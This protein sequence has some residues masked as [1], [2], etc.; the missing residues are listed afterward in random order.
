MIYIDDLVV[1]ILDPNTAMPIL[2]EAKHPN[3]LEIQEYIGT[4]IEKAFLDMNK[5]ELETI[6]NLGVKSI[7]SDLGKRD[8]FLERSRDFANFMYEILEKNAMEPL[9][10]VITRF[11]REGQEYVAIFYMYY[12]MSYIHTIDY[13]EEKNI[14][15]LLKQKTALPTENQKVDE[16]IFYNLETEEFFYKEKKHNVNGGKEYIISQYVLDI[17]MPLSPREKIDLLNKTSKKI[18]KDYYDNSINKMAEVN[19]IILD[20]VETK[21]YIDI[22]DV[23]DKA[24]HNQPDIQKAYEE[25]MVQKGLKDKSLEVE[26][27]ERRLPTFQK[28]LL[29]DGI[30][31]KIPVEVLNDKDKL[32]FIVNPDGSV[33]IMLKNLMD[34]QQK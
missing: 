13:D 27:L 30:E 12:K 24:F 34:I 3:D 25:E 20:N 8:D 17:T 14:N 1:H 29:D 32:E 16:F 18:V 19:S 6:G 11:T 5:K 23:K 9:D 7:L 15:R 26:G 31:M 33:S 28:I 2:S 22:D 10:L 4:H 21:G